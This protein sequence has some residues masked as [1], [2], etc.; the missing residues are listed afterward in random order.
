M[1]VGSVKPSVE[2]VRGR[3]VVA[4]LRADSS[5]CHDTH[6]HTHTDTHTQEWCALN[7]AG[8]SAGRP[9]APADHAPVCARARVCVCV[10][11]CVFPY[12]VW[13]RYAGLGAGML[14][15]RLGLG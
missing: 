10:C 7:T 13:M 14:V 15:R 1:C 6:T 8:Q 12:L 9:G 11:V 5:S 4:S 3:T 2:A